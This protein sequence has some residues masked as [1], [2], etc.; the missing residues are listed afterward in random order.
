ML[1][2]TEAIRASVAGVTDALRRAEAQT[3]R[4]PGSVRLVA[5]TKTVPTERVLEAWG[6]G[7]RL[8]GE[9]YVQEALPKVDRLPADAEW[10]FIG[11]LQSNKARQAAE[12]FS[13]V[14]SLDRPSLAE[15]LE[16]AASRRAAPL[17]VLLQVNVGDETSKAGTTFEGAVALAGRAADWPHLRV[18]GLMA[19]PPFCEDPERTRPHFRALRE[20]RNRIAALGLPGVEMAELSMGM[21]GDFPVAVEEGATLV[22]VGTALFG[23]RPPA[24]N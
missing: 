23:D 10:H 3:G 11:H 21:S 22:R 13:L 5:V 19:I 15:A 14:H 20:L 9:S 24:A 12:I 17:E 8:F 16:K 7:L 2:L 4:R 18:R 6:A 1:P